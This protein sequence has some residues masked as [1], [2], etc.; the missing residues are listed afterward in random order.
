[1]KIKEDNEWKEEIEKVENEL[2]E[3]KE[4]VGKKRMQ[5]VKEKKR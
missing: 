1:M 3:R 5:R 2:I 4:E